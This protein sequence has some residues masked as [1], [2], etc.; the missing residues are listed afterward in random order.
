MY[1]YR[2]E[3]IKITAERGLEIL[4][5]HQNNA[6]IMTN[7]MRKVWQGVNIFYKII[8]DSCEIH[9]GQILVHGTDILNSRLSNGY[10]ITVNQSYGVYLKL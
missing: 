2:L 6:V 8:L 9:L 5:I 3:K 10:L 7:G 4:R 1:S